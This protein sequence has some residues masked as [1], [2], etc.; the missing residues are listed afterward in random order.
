MLIRWLDP[1][2]G[3]LLKAGS[4]KGGG[5]KSFVPPAAATDGFSGCSIDRKGSSLTFRPV[6]FDDL[7]ELG[8]LA[9]HHLLHLRI[10]KECGG[11]TERIE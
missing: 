8:I 9:K 3:K 6:F 4:V 10:E 5:V 2:T 7:P 11:M 1:R